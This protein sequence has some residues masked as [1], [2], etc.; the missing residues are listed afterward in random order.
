MGDLLRKR[1]GDHGLNQRELAG[2]LQISRD[3][4]QA[5][6][7]DEATPSVEAW[8]KLANVLD[9]PATPNEALPNSGL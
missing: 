6:E 7:R 8:H 9:L 1:R 3:W 4:I 2:I 5:W